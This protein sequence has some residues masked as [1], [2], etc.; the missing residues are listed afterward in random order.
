MSGNT[1]GTFCSTRAAPSGALATGAF[2]GS[3]SCPH[4]SD[5]GGG[6]G[7]IF[8]SGSVVGVGSC[9]ASAGCGGGGGGK[10]FGGTIVV[11]SNNLV[12]GLHVGGAPIS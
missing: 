6:G 8:A 4:P 11:W 2:F 1:P 7:G 12:D 9:G 3:G 5:S 10:L